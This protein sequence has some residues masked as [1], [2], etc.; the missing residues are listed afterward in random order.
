MAKEFSQLGIAPNLL[1]LL[2]AMGIKQPMP[3]QEGAIPL[4]LKGRDVLAQ[5]RTGTGKTLSFLLPAMQKIDS[6][7][8]YA[9]VLIVTPTRELAV[10]ITGEA[11]RLVGD[12]GIQITALLGG[13][14][15]TDQKNKLEHVSHLLVGTPGRILDHVKRK[16]ASLGG[17]RFFVL[18]EVDEM[19]QRGFIDEIGQ[20]VSS[21]SPE[22]QTFVCSATM[23]VEVISLAKRIMNNPQRVEID[24]DKFDISSIEQYIVKVSEEKRQTALLELLRQANPYLAIVFCSSR[25]SAA[26]VGDWLGS[27]GMLCDVL[28]GELS[29]SKRLQVMRSF[30][31]AKIQVLVATDLAARGL[32]VEG[33]SHVVNYELPRDAQQYIHRVGR[34]GRAGASGTAITIYAPEEGGKLVKLEEKLGVVFKA[35]NLSGQ[36]VTRVSKKKPAVAKTGRAKTATATKTGH[37]KTSAAKLGQA[38][39]TMDKAKPAEQKTAASKVKAGWAVAKPKPERKKN[40]PRKKDTK[41]S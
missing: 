24:A 32:D 14:D 23:P 19:L 18:D 31:K 29:Q 37:P 35:R 38:K 39:T 1:A 40:G 10:Q 41:K 21:V 30:R 33:V 6:K 11:R 16:S 3:V 17:V 13:R 22:R 27:Q 4:V 8:P 15:F 36:E 26:T 9:Q 2:P 12:S 20:I 7:K 25:E 28:Q 34:T 5:A